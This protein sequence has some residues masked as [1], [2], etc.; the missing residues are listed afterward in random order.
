MTVKPTRALPKPVVEMSAEEKRKADEIDLRCL[1]LC[2]GMLE[3]VNG[4]CTMCYISMGLETE[5]VWVD[6]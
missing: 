3:R 2:I 4:V 6:I 1:S 5:T